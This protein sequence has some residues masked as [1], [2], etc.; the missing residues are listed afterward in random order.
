MK[1]LI[2]IALTLMAINAHAE[3]VSARGSLTTAAFTTEEAALDA[4]QDLIPGIV[5]ITNKRV[6]AVGA[7]NS[8]TRKPQ[9]IQVTGANVMRSFANVNGTLEARYT[10]IVSYAFTRCW[11]QPESN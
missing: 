7:M 11:K 6:R 4:A 3:W 9:Y 5:N 2:T 8:C 10:G 1:K